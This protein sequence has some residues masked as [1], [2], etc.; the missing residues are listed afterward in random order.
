MNFTNSQ[1]QAVSS[2]GLPTLINAGAG[3]GKTRVIIEKAGQFIEKGMPPERLALITFTK[4]ATFEMLERLYERVGIVAYKACVSNWHSFALNQVVKPAM[5]KGHPYFDLLGYTEKDIVVL[6]ES[7]SKTLIGECA[8]AIL[9]TADYELLVENGGITRVQGFI[10]YQLSYGKGP[11][12]AYNDKMEALGNNPN[13]NEVDLLQM[14]ILIWNAYFKRLIELNAVDYDHILIHACKLLKHDPKLRS[15]IQ[16]FYLAV[17]ADEHQDANPV[18]GEFLK[19]IVGDGNNLTLVGDDKQS[20]YGFRAADVGQFI[21]AKTEYQGMN[22]IEMA[23]NFRSSNR[24][25]DLANAV[26]MLMDSSQKVTDGI[27]IAKSGYEGDLPIARRYK[28]AEDE[29]IGVVS[30]MKSLIESGQ[31]QQS[32]FAILYRA[33]TIKEKLESELVRQG[34][35]YRVVGDNDFFDSKEIKDWVAFLRFSAND[36][37]VMAASRVID[38]AGIKSRGVT[39]RRALINEEISI[40]QYL[41]KMTTAGTKKSHDKQQGFLNLIECHETLTEILHECGSINDLAKHRNIDASDES[42]QVEW[43]QMLSTI[44]RGLMTIWQQLFKAKLIEDAKKKYKTKSETA[45]VLAEVNQKETNVKTLNARLFSFIESHGHLL[46]CIKQLNLL[47]DSGESESNSVQLMTLH[48]S[49]G[50]EFKQV[51]IVGCEDESH[52]RG[53]DDDDEHEEKRLFYVGITRA[54]KRLTVSCSCQRTVWG[55]S[56]A[57]TPLRFLPQLPVELFNWQDLTGGSLKETSLS[58]QK[59]TTTNLNSHSNNPIKDLRM[60]IYEEP[61]LTVNAKEI[62]VEGYKI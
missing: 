35:D 16:Q 13:Q 51:Y 25:V 18:Q 29:A 6:N 4:K 28:T 33:K 24:I 17:L 31:C 48:A 10:S 46:D 49:K 8:K 22:I 40:Q 15:W 52:F 14:T 37:D 26:A 34:V 5:V 58:I 39:M 20:I 57:R 44:E 59:P 45:E 38:A 12:T 55:K 50:L 61:N 1:S 2:H 27:M 43:A 53:R 56:M 54:E 30:E 19:L 32:D 62:R 47:I 11:K 60:G 23:E 42:L 36:K 21:N 9:S 3:S 7:E 41:Q